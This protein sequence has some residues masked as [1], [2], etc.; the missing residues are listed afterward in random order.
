[1]SRTG[2]VPI[3]IPEGVEVVKDNLNL[4]IKGKSGIGQ[5]W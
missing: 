3:D 2:N 4:I 1:M 5:I